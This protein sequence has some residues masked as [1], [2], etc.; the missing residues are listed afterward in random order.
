MIGKIIFQFAVGSIFAFGGFCA[1]W[2]LCN[3]VDTFA[4][5]TVDW[6]LLHLAAVYLGLPI[7]SLLGIF[8]VDKLFF[9]VQGYNVLG[10]PVGFLLCVLAIALSTWFLQ[11]T[12][13]NIGLYLM[14]F[15]ASFFSLIGYNAAGL[16]QLF[17]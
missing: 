15:I 4:E 10:I 12:R 8:L 16:F 7:G 17:K 11:G 14:P 5:I 9:K 3:L 13:G 2:V 6:V 1:A